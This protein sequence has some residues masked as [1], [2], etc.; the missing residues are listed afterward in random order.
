MSFPVLATTRLLD[1][2]AP[3]RC[4]SCAREGSWL[5]HTCLP[6]YSQFRQRCIVC[7]KNSTR[8]ITCVSCKDETPL[9]GIVSAGSYSYPGLRRGISWLKFKGIRPVAE[10]LASLLIPR[11]PHVA[12]M[13][14][15]AQSAVLVPI[16]LHS[17]RQRQ[18]GFNQSEDIARAI[19]IFTN[20]SVLNILQR[21]KATW[22]QAKLPAEMRAQ[23]PQDAFTVDTSQQK[24]FFTTK[25]IYILVDDVTT[26]GAT[27]SA[28]AKTLQQQ[29]PTHYQLWAA[30]IAQG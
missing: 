1:L 14:E 24:E 21:T 5:C 29:L 18:R 9:T 13:S 27:L 16:P 8:G 26:S 11:L 19:H 3:P 23:N 22:A 4:M 28:A 25:G 7:S 12:S 30:T 2:V 10:T 6:L 15:L 17:R 20:I